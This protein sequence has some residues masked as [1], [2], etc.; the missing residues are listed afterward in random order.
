MCKNTGEMTTMITFV[1]AED[2]N[3]V[4]GNNGKL[5]W[6]LPGDMQFFK[7]ITLTGDVLMGRKTFESIPNPPLPNRENLVMTRNKEFSHEGVTVFHSKEEVLKWAE[8]HEKPLHII[9]GSVLF[10]QFVSNVD[11]LY[12]T[13]IHD[14]FDGDTY[15]SDI[16]YSQFDLVEERE[17]VVNEANKHAHTFQIFKRKQNR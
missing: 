17:G 16:D 14:S 8:T 10:E 7:E 9:G 1:W 6:H 5:P 15:M 3:G 11:M 2:E 12:R 13:L 4:I